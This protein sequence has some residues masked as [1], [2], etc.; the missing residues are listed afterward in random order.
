VVLGELVAPL[1]DIDEF[2]DD[3]PRWLGHAVKVESGTL[4][5]ADLALAPAAPIRAKILCAAINYV[6]HGDE[7]ELEPPAFP[8]LFARWPAEM[9]ADGEA[10]PVPRSEPEGLDWEVELGAI[11]GKTLTDVDE[12]EAEAGLFGFVVANDISARVS[13]VAA[14]KIVNGQWALGKNPEKS[15]AVG[16]FIETADGFTYRNRKLETRLNGAI[17]Q[18]G[19]TNEMIFSVGQIIALAS[20]HVTLRPGDLILT[21]TPAGVGWARNPRILM[22]PGDTISV[23]VEGIGSLTNPIVG[24]SGRG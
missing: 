16:S 2:Y 18:S 15:C 6:A 4:A 9:V 7:A 21:G 23:S 3:L 11:V 8:N 1:T 17:M 22:N 13:Q 10:V 20:K 19:N 12:H 5:L 24:A 14:T